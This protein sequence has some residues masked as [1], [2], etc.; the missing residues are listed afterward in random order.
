MPSWFVQMKVGNWLI[1]FCS[2]HQED[3]NSKYHPRC[4]KSSEGGHRKSTGFPRI[5]GPRTFLLEFCCSALFLDWWLGYNVGTCYGRYSP[6][7]SWSTQQAPAMEGAPQG[8]ADLPSPASDFA[9][10]IMAGNLPDFLESLN[11][12]SYPRQCCLKH[13]SSSPWSARGW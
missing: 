7:G 12:L 11:S 13:K 3:G 1:Q 9:S 10:Q 4:K 2:C 5:P 8:R 6:R